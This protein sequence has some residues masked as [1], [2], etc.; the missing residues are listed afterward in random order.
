MN[1]VML[2]VLFVAVG[3]P[4][5]GDA[6]DLYEPTVRTM[7]SIVKEQVAREAEATKTLRLED[8]SPPR[9]IERKTKEPKLIPKVIEPSPEAVKVRDTNAK[10]TQ[11]QITVQHWNDY[12]KRDP[13]VRYLTLEHVD[14]AYRANWINAIRF[15]IPSASRARELDHQ[16]PRQLLGTLSFYIDLKHLGWDPIDLNKVLEKYP[17][18]DND[19]NK[20]I[21]TIR[22]DWLLHE[23]ADARNSDTL[24][25]LMY[26][27]KNIPKTD[28][29]FLKFWGVDKTQQDGQWYGW[30]E[31]D[32]QV[33]KSGVRFLEH[34]NGRG[35]SV[36]RT[37]DARKV[38]NK[39]DPLTT[40]DG[41]FTH[42]GREL[43]AQFPKTSVRGRS[44]GAAQAYL[45]ANAEGKRVEEAPVDLVED[46][47]RTFDAAI[48]NTASCTVCHDKGMQLPSSNAV[49][50]VVLRGMTI[51]ALGKEK[52]VFIEDFHLSDVRMQLDRDIENYA[53]FVMACNGLATEE[54]AKNY[55]LCLDLFNRKVSLTDAARE[56]GVKDEELRLAIGYASANKINLGNRL[57][58][59]AY[60]DSIH[61]D[62]WEDDFERAYQIVRI[63]KKG[64]QAPKGGDSK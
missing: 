36:W 63:W 25:R 15:A 64:R 5:S 26:G 39:T 32:S 56:L 27:E 17:Y 13:F 10:F 52:Q 9:K 57:L 41:E 12:A 11:S 38:T 24:Y 23:L 49:E 40:L 50:D 44:R 33:N 29:D 4:L 20:P 18:A 3:G 45:L 19:P 43:I 16:I 48:V 21:L 28:E 42:D 2:A 54:N 35:F 61:R 59:L 47:K 1:T 7:V 62:Q 60:G 58:S 31:R 14:P 46:H 30:I 53:I 34:F 6:L 37:K 8:L 51:N 22:G 55:K